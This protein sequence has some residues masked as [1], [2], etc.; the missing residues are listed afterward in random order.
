M[1]INASAVYEKHIQNFISDISLWVGVCVCGQG[2]INDTECIT[3]T[4]DRKHVTVK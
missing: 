4:R 1:K 3:Q 2:N